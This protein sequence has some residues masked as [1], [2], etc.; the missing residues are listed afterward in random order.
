MIKMKK[1]HPQAKLP[2]YESSGAACF[3]LYSVEQDIIQGSHSKVFRTGLIFE[4]P[5]GYCMKVYSRSG[6]GF[7]NG[8]RLA[9]CV[10]IVDSDYRSEVLVKL[11]NDSVNPYYV[12][13]GDRIAQA[14]I[15]PVT[16]YDFGWADELS[17]TERGFGGFG[18]TGR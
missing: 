17:E 15:V 5:E 1:V 8:V 14:E 7:K 6:M 4:I 9:N 10:G 11:T 18:S 16:R 2:T 3:D 12:Q 13:L